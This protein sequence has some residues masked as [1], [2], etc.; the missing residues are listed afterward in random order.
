MTSPTNP[1]KQFYDRHHRPAQGQ[2]PE[3]GLTPQAALAG[4]R[5]AGHRYFCLF[6]QIPEGRTLRA[7]ELGF[8]SATVAAAL[9]HYFGFYE[10]VDIS[11]DVL[12]EGHE[13]GF[14]HRQANLCEDFPYPDGSFD[15]VIA[16]MI[17]EHLFDPFHSFREIARIL[18]PQG[19]AFV[20]LPNITSVRCRLDLLRGRLPWTSRSDWFESR[21]WDGGHLHYFDIGHVTRLGD[22][23][24]LELV[25]I[26]PVGR[27]YR[28]KRLWPDLLCHELSYVFKRRA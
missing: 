10:T 25:R 21:E 7:V 1:I 9:A 17:V 22:L 23:Y 18:K 6:D 2:E 15:V 12:L 19:T 16:M 5:R 13:A 24:G 26:Y 27:F 11:A 28:L 8:G 14:P 4:L 20:N 3:A